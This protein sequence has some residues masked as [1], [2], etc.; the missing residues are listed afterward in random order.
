MHP[1]RGA[2]LENSRLTRCLP[3]YEKLLISTAGNSWTC[4][5]GQDEETRTMSDSKKGM[6]RRKFFGG[7]HGYCCWS[8]VG[9]QP[10][11]MG[12]WT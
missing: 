6:D 11:R 10:S 5:A 12:R 1:S 7:E 9:R 4:F 8:R 3:R 2:R